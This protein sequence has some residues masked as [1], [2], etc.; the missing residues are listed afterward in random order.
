[1]DDA[2]DRAWTVFV[3]GASLAYRERGHGEPVV[4]VHG[5]ASDMRTWS[6][7]LPALSA[8]YRAVAYSRRYARPNEDIPPGADDPMDAHVEDLLAFMKEID[9]FP[10]HLVGH[11]W[12]AFICLLAAIARPEAVRSL[13]LME[14]PVL[15][16]FVSTPPRPGELFKTLLH[17][18]RTA[19]AI[20]KFGATAVAPAQKAYRR[21]DDGRGFEI[22]GRGV[23][24][25]KAFEQLSPARRKQSWENRATD[26]AQLLGEGFP[27]LED[28]DVRGVRKPVLLMHGQKSPTIFHL[29]A[30]RLE[31]LLPN[32]ERLEVP[33][34]SHVV[35]EDNPR[36]VNEAVL[37]FLKRLTSATR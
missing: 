35:H 7:Q 36:A 25:K 5:S 22:F 4:L 28:D 19:L 21:G 11:S 6:H 37:A 2:F 13:V 18:P 1:M 34:A 16:L 15:S 10:A 24:G 23:L 30:D 29:L 33:R 31:D 9:A 12:G 8:S 3:R 32:V 26:K 17:R 14:P 20:V 27:P